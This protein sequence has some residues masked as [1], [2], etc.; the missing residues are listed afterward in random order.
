MRLSRRGFTLLEVTIA[1]GLLTTMMVATY[2]L[3]FQSQRL[4]H[5]AQSAFDQDRKSQIFLRR[6][7][8][9]LRSALPYIHPEEDLDFQGSPE[10]LRFCTSFFQSEKLSHQ[11]PAYLHLGR[12]PDGVFFEVFPA[13]FVQI[14]AERKDAGEILRL[15]QVQELELE[16][17]DGKEWKDEWA[18]RKLLKLP[19]ALRVRLQLTRKTPEGTQADPVEMIV[20]FPVIRDVGVR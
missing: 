1:V 5:A 20:P 7:S 8:R 3:F 9:T 2:R 4:A 12:D 15:D 16:Y 13:G 18:L 10:D 6:L 17:Y 11:G 14:E 19:A